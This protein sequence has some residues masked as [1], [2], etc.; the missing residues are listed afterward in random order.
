MSRILSQDFCT[1]P[2]LVAAL[3]SLWLLNLDCPYWTKATGWQGAEHAERNRLPTYFTGPSP[4]VTHVEAERLCAALRMFGLYSCLASKNAQCALWLLWVSIIY[5]PCVTLPQED[6]DCCLSQHLFIGNLRE[7]QPSECQCFCPFI[8]IQAPHLATT[9]S[10]FYES[11][12][13][14]LY[15]LPKNARAW[16]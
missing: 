2:L 5:K 3:P 14:L 16:H 12:P 13:L 10:E 15:S 9:D 6:A 4:M 1:F 11:Q 8:F 7:C